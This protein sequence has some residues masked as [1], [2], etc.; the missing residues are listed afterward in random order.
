[1]KTTFISIFMVGIFFFASVLNAQQANQPIKVKGFIEPV[2]ILPNL[3]DE[4]L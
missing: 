2:G 1:M 3:S 4:Y